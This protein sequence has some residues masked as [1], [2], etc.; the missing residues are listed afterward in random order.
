M[1][2]SLHLV[3]KPIFHTRSRRM[4]HPAAEGDSDSKYEKIA[5]DVLDLIQRKSD[6]V[7]A[8]LLH[9]ETTPTITR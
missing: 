9:I 2:L 7:F 4:T 8:R 1:R 6:A 3:S 5:K